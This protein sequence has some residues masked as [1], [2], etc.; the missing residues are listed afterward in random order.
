[1]YHVPNAYYVYVNILLGSS[2][3]Y[4]LTSRPCIKGS[5][6]PILIGFPGF[7]VN[8]PLHKSVTIATLIFFFLKLIN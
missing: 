8:F 5:R 1:M 2:V 4:W 7:L 3:A 6:V